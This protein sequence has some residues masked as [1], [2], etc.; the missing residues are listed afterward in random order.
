M[1]GRPRIVTYIGSHLEKGGDDVNSNQPTL[2][3]LDP[4]RRYPVETSLKYLDICRATFYR[5]VAAG[6]I[7]TIKQGKRR[8]VPGSEI[9]RLSSIA[10]AA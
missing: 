7:K 9:A 2:G 10:I 6:N 1:R 3:P 5:E 8:F 4:L